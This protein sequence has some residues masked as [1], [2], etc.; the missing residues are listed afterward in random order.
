MRKN[1]RMA[2]RWPRRGVTTAWSR[3]DGNGERTKQTWQIKAI[4]SG[5]RFY[6][7]GA[8]GELSSD[9]SVVFIKQPALE[10]TWV[11]RGGG[12]FSSRHT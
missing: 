7:G 3:E 10:E 4:D 12:G 5:D 6:G 1:W 8:G 9:G 11:W 2:P